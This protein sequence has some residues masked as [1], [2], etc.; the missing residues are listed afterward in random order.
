MGMNSTR[1]WRTFAIGSTIAII[2]GAA[3]LY[4]MLVYSLVQ[5]RPT[6]LLACMESEAPW[7]AW[8]CE[9]VLQ[10]ASLTPDHVLELNQTN[11]AMYPMLMD[12]P[13]QAEKMLSLF[14]SRGVDINARDVNTRGWTALHVVT[15]GE[16]S[17]KVSIL[18]KHGA[19]TDLRD[20]DGRTPLDLARQAWQKQPTN[21]NIA[22]TVR[23]LEDAQEKSTSSFLVTPSPG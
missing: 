21:P 20:S 14:L 7:Y 9:Q 5:S 4:A 6:H 22:E 3:G 11:G 23:L 15:L 19:R 10:H 12:D 2:L 13:E 17:E 1:T 18:I 8:T 16:P